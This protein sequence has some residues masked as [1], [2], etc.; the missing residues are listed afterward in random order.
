MKTIIIPTD[1]SATSF[2]AAEYACRLAAF[3]NAKVWFFHTYQIPVAVGEFAFAAVDVA[4]MQKAAEHELQLM[5]TKVLD[6]LGFN[7]DISTFAIIGELQNELRNFCDVQKPDLVV[8]G[9]TG[10]NALTQLI[11]GSNTIVTINELNYP[12]LVIPPRA[13]FNPIRKIGF[14][15]DFKHVDKE[16]PVKLIREI[17]KDFNADLFVLNVDFNNENFEST[18][19]DERFTLN[20]LLKDINVEYRNIESEDV[21]EG[22]NWFAEQ[23][24]IDV[25][26]TIPKKHTLLQKIFGRSHTKDL[27]YHT[28]IPV[29]CIHQ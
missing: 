16:V 22:I 10:K 18:I 9:L 24:T 6:K 11:V 5:K 13:S 21:T 7:A 4:Q 25:L 3:Y 28:H 27:I 23:A 20:Q 8:M 17:V 15:C 14:A 26:V 19:I 2:N 12:V 1:F 29:L